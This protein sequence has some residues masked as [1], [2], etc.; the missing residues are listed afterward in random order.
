MLT[1][2]SETIDF[3]F[4]NETLFWYLNIVQMMR[5]ELVVM[6]LLFFGVAQVDRSRVLFN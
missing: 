5:W 3:T 4:K 2:T 6:H 1:H